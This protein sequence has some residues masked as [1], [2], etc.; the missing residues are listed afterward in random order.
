MDPTQRED[1]MVPEGSNRRRYPRARGDWPVVV[2]LPDGPH[3][4]RVRDVSKGGVCFFLDRPIPE[5]TLLSVEFDLPC[6]A[7]VRHIRG[8]GAVVRCSKISKALD[9][10]EIAVFL[11]E[12]ADPDRATIEAFV[13]ETLLV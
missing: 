8:T 12:M 6:S 1:L 2:E 7:G 13:T 5:M 4:A 11:T 3:E 9:H 10:Y